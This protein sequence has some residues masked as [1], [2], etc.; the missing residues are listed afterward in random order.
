ME[1]RVKPWVN[2]KIVEYIGEEEASLVDFIC[3]KVSTKTTAPTLLEDIAMVSLFTH[4][5]GERYL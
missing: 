3:Q 1:R 2:K 5:F 4:M